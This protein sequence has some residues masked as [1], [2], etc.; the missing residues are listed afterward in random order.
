M[1][2]PHSAIMPITTGPKYFEPAGA[3]SKAIVIDVHDG[4]GGAIDQCAFFFNKPGRWWVR[5]GSAIFLGE[6]EIV[7]ARWRRS[8]LLLHETPRQWFVSGCEGAVIIDWA[9]DI[10]P[11]L[12]GLADLRCSSKALAIQVREKLA[13]PR[14]YVGVAQGDRHVA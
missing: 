1:N 8:T 5:T 10:Y 6:P 7:K 14:L 11:T 3:G 4:D 2:I 12:A 13:R 9:A